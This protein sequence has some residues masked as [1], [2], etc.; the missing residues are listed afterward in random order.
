MED[1]NQLQCIVCSES[2]KKDFLGSINWKTC[3]GCNYINICFSCLRS[4]D[5]KCPI[6][7]ICKESYENKLQC[8]IC[9]EYENKI[10]CSR[11]IT[12]KEG[13][14]CFH[15]GEEYK[16][17]HGIYNIKC[18][19]CR[20]FYVN[21]ILSS[22][23]TDTLSDIDYIFDLNKNNLMK[24]WYNNYITTEQFLDQQEFYRIESIVVSI[25]SNIKKNIILNELFKFYLNNKYNDIRNLEII[26]LHKG[27]CGITKNMRLFFKENKKKITKEKID[28]YISFDK[29][30]IFYTLN[31]ESLKKQNLYNVFYTN[32]QETDMYKY[33]NDNIRMKLINSVF[34]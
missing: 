4:D 18:P 11:C 27:T 28:E 31:Q 5:I 1:S 22:I 30:F 9:M 10:C 32:F 20:K 23:I 21:E 3:G 15:C 26:F 8:V 6:C 7:P 33:I 13:N 14:I 29:L 34:K 2:L 17:I 16:K 24:I 25:I 19:I 12:C